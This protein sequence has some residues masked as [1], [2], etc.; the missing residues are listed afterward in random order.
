MCLFVSIPAAVGCETHPSFPA[1]STPPAQETRLSPC[2]QLVAGLWCPAGAGIVLPDNGRAA[3]KRRIRPMSGPRIVSPLF[4]NSQHLANPVT[5][6]GTF[7]A[8][9]LLF[10]FCFFFGVFL[11]SREN[12]F[13]NGS[14]FCGLL[15][16]G[17]ESH[18]CLGRCCTLQ[19][20]A[21]FRGQCVSQ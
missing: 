8:F 6:P 20:M 2:C 14:S 4:A 18:P 7:K 1:F 13:G 17:W 9:L 16:K 10:P 5:Q 21:R 11:Q 15:A 19:P 12:S 3:R